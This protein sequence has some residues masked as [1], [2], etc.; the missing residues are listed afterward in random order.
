MNILTIIQ[1]YH[2]VIGGSE[3]LTKTFMD[4]LSKN[5]TI[6]IYSTI[7]KDIESF[8]CGDDQTI[9]ENNTLD[10]KVTKHDFLIPTQ[11]KHDFTLD[12]FNFVTTHPGP[13][14]PKL[15]DKLFLKKNNFDLIFA[16]AFPYDHILPAYAAAKKLKIPIITMPLIHQEFP[17]LFL[18]A[19]KLTILNNS[20]GVVVLSNS[21]KSLLTNSG[22]SPEKISVIKPTLIPKKIKRS[23]TLR[24]K[25]KFLSDFKGEIILFIGHKS[26]MKGIF[27]LI[28]SMKKIWK[29]RKNVLLLLIGPTTND[30]ETYFSTLSMKFK[31]QIIDLGLV[32]EEKKHYAL[33]LCDIFVLPSKSESFGLVYVEAWL[34]AK[35]V[36]GCTLNS[37]SDVIDTQKNGILTQFGNISELERAILLL[38]DNPSMR[39]KFGKHGK[40]KS[41]KYTSQDN[42]KNF[43]EL[44]QNT[45]TTFN[46]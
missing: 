36:I 40:T 28:E 35:P 21:E 45:I 34:Y 11:I 26:T 27:H 9:S 15:W 8:W 25:T 37:V 23:D 30:F 19:I 5:H 41:L 6:T 20:D 33:S 13:F 2:P 32:S 12:K 16:T 17:E 4:Y 44:C 3:N 1:R 42:F 29:K 38:L 43:E 46:S 10:Y 7:A 14:S 39:I 18:S 24:F 22:I 31:N